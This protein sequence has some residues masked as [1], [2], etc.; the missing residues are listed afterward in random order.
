M[1]TWSGIAVTQ[2]GSVVRGRVLT[3]GGVSIARVDSP[4][5]APEGAEQALLEAASART[6]RG[7][8]EMPLRWAGREIRVVV[9]G[10]VT[11]GVACVES[12]TGDVDLT[13]AE[14]ARAEAELLA[15]SKRDAARL[16]ERVPSYR[17][18]A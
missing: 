8:V 17:R 5:P 2:S 4:E 13:P 7:G 14:E 1:Q 12:V 6:W 16:A 11:D 15:A 10:S 3:A 9:S 18:C